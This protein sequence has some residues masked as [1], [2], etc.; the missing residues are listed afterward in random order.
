M[1]TRL[2]LILILSWNSLWTQDYHAKTLTTENGLPSD[3]IYCAYEDSKGYIWIGTKNGVA[4]WDS[5]NFEYFTIKDGLPNNEVVGIVED[6]KGRIWFQTFNNEISYFQNNI[7]YNK[8]NDNRLGHFYLRSQTHFI[9]FGGYI[10]FLSKM[11][12]P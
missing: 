8:L 2:I 3:V 9:E 5:K 1:K 4:R 12:N 11:T 10:H 6:S 7:I